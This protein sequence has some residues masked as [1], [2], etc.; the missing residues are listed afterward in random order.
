MR[1]GSLFQKTWHSK[2]PPLCPSITLQ[3]S[4]VVHIL[5]L[6]TL[7]LFIYLS[8][9]WEVKEG[10]QVTLT[11]PCD[12][13]I[14]AIAS[15][16][17][18]TGSFHV[19]MAGERIQSA[20]FTCGRA[21]LSGP[22][23]PLRTIFN[24][25][26]EYRCARHLQSIS[27]LMRCDAALL[28]CRKSVSQGDWPILVFFSYLS[29][30]SFQLFLSQIWHRTGGGRW[31]RI[32]ERQSVSAVRDIACT[33]V[34]RYTFRFPP[35]SPSACVLP[36]SVPVCVR[37]TELASCSC[38]VRQYIQ[39]SCNPPLGFFDTLREPALMHTQIRLQSLYSSPS[40]FLHSIPVC[41]FPLCICLSDFD[42]L[43]YTH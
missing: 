36:F 33:Q 29:S 30:L 17:M 24:F 20:D 5:L 15:D 13:K 38:G 23:R 40:W 22:Q 8:I 34:S 2:W 3:Y 4:K 1:I 21:V 18:K 37:E 11:L 16:S 9:F 35:F 43:L 42:K 25:C 32:S 6:G 19:S 7:H 31:R 10:E 41:M 27:G 14:K 12:W 28:S 39:L 26:V